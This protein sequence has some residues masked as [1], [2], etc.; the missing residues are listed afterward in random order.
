LISKVPPKW[1]SLY[2][3][4]VQKDKLYQKICYLK[5]GDFPADKYFSCVVAYQKAKRLIFQSE[6]ETDQIQLMVKTF[7]WIKMKYDS[8]KLY[9]YNFV[10]KQ[11]TDALPTDVKEMNNQIITLMG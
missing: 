5:P 6:L 3:I 2:G 4:G 1:E 11:K 10:T 7:S 8:G 9:F